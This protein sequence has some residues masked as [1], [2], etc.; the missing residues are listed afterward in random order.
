MLGEIYVNNNTKILAFLQ[1]NDTGVSFADL[2]QMYSIQNHIVNDKHFQNILKNTL[3]SNKS[4][5]RLN[6]AT[7]LWQ[8]NQSNSFLYNTDAKRFKTIREAMLYVFSKKV[9]SGSAYFKVDDLHNAWFPQFDNDQWENILTDDQRYWLERPKNN[10]NYEPDNKLRY[11]FAHEKDGY[12]FTGVF[13]FVE[14]RNES[15]RVYELIDDK[16]LLSKPM[17]IC[18]ITWMK[19]YQGITDSDRPIGGGSYVDEN[20]DAFEKYNF[21]EQADGLVHGFVET[22]YSQGHT[23]DMKYANSIHIENLD[24]SVK[25]ASSVNGVRVVFVS[26]NHEIGK[27]V[28]VGWYDNAIIYRQRFEYNGFYTTMTCAPH[29]AH[30]IPEK[31]RNFVVPKASKENEFGIGQSNLW[32]IQ[33]F[34]SAKSLENDINVYLDSM[35]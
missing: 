28:I 26:Y 18:R 9:N 22:K 10:A 12:R 19:E 21:L 23:A 4:L 14:M 17:L 24:I 32:Y 6:K 2:A 20:N 33:N 7:G 15:T 11:V 27:T 34:E 25:N 8:V 1:K 35:I 3:E 29:D 5:Y 13:K 16:V 31:D 30:L